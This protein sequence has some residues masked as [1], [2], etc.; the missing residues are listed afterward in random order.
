MTEI[1]V[2]MPQFLGMRGKTLSLVVSVVATTGFLR[3]S[4]FAS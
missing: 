1:D 3:K 4:S 2:K